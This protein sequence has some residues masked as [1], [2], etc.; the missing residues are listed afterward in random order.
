MKGY[1]IE[2]EYND[3]NGLFKKVYCCTVYNDYNKAENELSD[4]ISD[5]ERQ[6]CANVQGDIIEVNNG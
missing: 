6:G 1:K 3:E 2:Y 4:I 5:L